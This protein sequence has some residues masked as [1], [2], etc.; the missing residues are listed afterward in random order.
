MVDDG[1][2]PLDT[3]TIY[4]D[5]LSWP[6][7]GDVSISAADAFL[8]FRDVHNGELRDSVVFEAW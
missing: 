1:G 5:C 6:F 8:G 2:H 4:L 7:L 3:R